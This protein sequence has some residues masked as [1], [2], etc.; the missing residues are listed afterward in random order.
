MTL[1]TIVTEVP[2]DM[3]RIRSTIEIRCMTLIAI[4]VCQLVVSIHMTCLAL[5]SNVSPCQRE[6]RCRMIK[7]GGTPV[8]R[9]MTLHAVV[10]K[11]TGHVIR[12]RCAAKISCM[13]LIAIVVHQLVVIVCVTILTLR[14]S[15]CAGQREVCCRMV[16]RGRIPVH[17]R[18]TL[19]AVMAEIPRNV[20][21]IS[22]RSE[23]RGMALVAIIIHE[24]IV[25]IGMARLTLHR[26]MSS[27]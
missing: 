26:N 25:A 19:N 24:L 9:R 17:G 1:G 8:N 27:R 22:S 5:G 2:S 6:V 20:I 10:T 3:V 7:C 16:K 13:A 18:V 14:C 11:V 21:W 4:S 23:I 12:I 15:M